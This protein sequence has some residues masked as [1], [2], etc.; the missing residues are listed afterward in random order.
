VAEAVAELLAAVGYDALTIEGV[1]ARAG[2]AKTTVYRRW[3]SKIQLVADS[4]SLRVN[5]RVIASD[6]GSL[7]GDLLAHMQAICTNLTTPIGQAILSLVAGMRHN[8]ELAEALRQG[9]VSLRR[10]EIAE[11]LGR[12]DARGELRPGFDHELVVDLIVSPLWYRAL[13]WGE[14]PERERLE[15]LVDTLLSGLMVVTG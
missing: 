2:V 5:T 1:A 9:Y 6:T 7:R 12:A 3:S 8:P 11:L 10:A 4:L 13:V 14:C 15:A